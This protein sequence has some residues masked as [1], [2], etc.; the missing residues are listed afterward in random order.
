VQ[1][2]T[3]VRTCVQKGNGIA[4]P[5]TGRFTG[6]TITTT[7]PGADCTNQTFK[8]TGGLA[9]L[10]GGGTGV[11]SVK[12][13]HWRHTVLGVCLSYFATTDGT[14]TLSS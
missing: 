13:T 6:G 8:V 12:L 3:G 14:L 10:N 4:D 5:L 2:K 1:G 11:F 9:H 7:N